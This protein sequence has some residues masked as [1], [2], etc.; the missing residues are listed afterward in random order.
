MTNIDPNTVAAALITVGFIMTGIT[1]FLY[2]GWECR[3]PRVTQLPR[4]AGGAGW[5]GRR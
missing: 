1:L 2:F 4:S 3:R 5:L